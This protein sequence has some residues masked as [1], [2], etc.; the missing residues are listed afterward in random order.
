MLWEWYVEKRGNRELLWQKEKKAESIIQTTER[1]RW[2]RDKDTKALGESRLG[3]PLWFNMFPVSVIIIALCVP[4]CERGRRSSD[5]TRGTA[6]CYCH[7]RGNSNI[8]F[9]THRY[10]WLDKLV[11]C[12]DMQPHLFLC[13]FFGILLSDVAVFFI[14][15]YFFCFSSFRLGWNLS[16]KQGEPNGQPEKVDRGLVP[17]HGPLSCFKYA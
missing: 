10:T 11:L 16:I 5:V 8:P 2:V 3:S 4:L 6:A 17:A 13:S 7:Y 9:N 1:K 14:L 15:F 12:C